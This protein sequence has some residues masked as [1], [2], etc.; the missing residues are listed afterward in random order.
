MFNDGEIIGESHT[1]PVDG[2][3]EVEGIVRLF[4]TVYYDFYLF[5]LL[6]V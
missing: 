4:E 2:L 1:F 3:A 5:G 6:P